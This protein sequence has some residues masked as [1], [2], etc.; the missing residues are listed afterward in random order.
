MDPDKVDAI[1]KWKSPTNHDLLC[2]FL[3]SVGFLADDIA[4]VQ[5]PMGHLHAIT[6]DNVPF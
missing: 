1:L 3:G 5:V 6:G 4:E 2:G